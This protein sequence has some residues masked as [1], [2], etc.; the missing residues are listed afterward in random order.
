[1]LEIGVKDETTTDDT[2]ADDEA[3]RDDEGLAITV[4]VGTVTVVVN[5]P[6]ITP[7]NPHVSPIPNLLLW[8]Y[9]HPTPEH[10]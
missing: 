7:E 8:L 5:V 4:A 3:S 6:V 9:L 1:M 10:P 2:A